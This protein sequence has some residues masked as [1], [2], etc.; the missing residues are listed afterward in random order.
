MR[1]EMCSVFFDN[2]LDSIHLHLSV[3]HRLFLDRQ[4]RESCA[5]PQSSSYANTLADS[6]NN[7]QVR[8]IKEDIIR[9][10]CAY[11]AKIRSST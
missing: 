5:S 6:W 4:Q 1:R 9:K 7:E 11:A 8:K 3:W 2:I 10:A